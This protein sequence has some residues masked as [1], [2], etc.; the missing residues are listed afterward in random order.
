[1]SLRSVRVFVWTVTLLAAALPAAA[2]LG[3]SSLQG[4]YS[5]RYLG[6]SL[7]TTAAPCSDCPVS[8]IGTVTF[9]GAGGFTVSGQG[10]YVNSSG[11]TQT[12]TPAASGT[13][14][15]YSSGMFAMANPF[16]PASSATYLYGGVGQGVVVASSTESNNLDTFVAF[17]AATAASNATLSGTYQVGSLEFAGGAISATRNNIFSMTADGK[18]GLGNVSITGTSLQLNNSSTTVT[19]VSPGA[20]YSVTSNGSG[21]LTLPAPSGVSAA[22][23]LLSG[24]KTLYVSADGNVFIAGTPAGYDLIV[25]IKAMPAGSANPPVTGLYFITELEN[26]YTTAGSSIYAYQGATNELGDKAA[27][28]LLHLRTN[29]DVSSPYDE[30]FDFNYSFNSAGV[31]PATGVTFAAGGNG[32]LYIV[33]GGGGDYYLALGVK[34]QPITASGVFLSPYGV[35]NAATNSPFTAQL[36]PGEAITLY[37]SGM[38]PAGTLATASAPF[39]NALAGVGVTING[40]IAPVYFVTPTQINAVVPYS[41]DP[42]ATAILSVQV[43]NGT[44]PSNI[45]TEYLGTTSPGVFTVPSGGLGSGAVLH[46]DYTLVTASSPAKVNEVIQIFLTGLGAVS[47]AVNAGAPAPSTVPLSTTVNQPDVY[48]DGLTAKVGYSGLAPGLGGLYQLNVTVP[49]GVTANAN[50]TLEVDGLDAITFQ[51][52]IPIGK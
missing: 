44:T 25:G 41:L 40:K 3:N 22:S 7:G 14:T 18:G 24:V 12:L 38:A 21:T 42:T 6:V 49:T 35:V 20:T 1:M 48:I 13:Y 8:F 37:G 50:V 30:T 5:F 34:V 46:A 36:S 51:A 29:S 39:P 4:A 32:N 19:Q 23:Q 11:A 43:T 9:D 47:P 27:T 15:V 45:V 16:A 10:N 31:S 33:A 2:Q 17:P 52:T 26:Y 28:E